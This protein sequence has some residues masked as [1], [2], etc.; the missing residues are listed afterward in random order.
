MKKFFY[1]LT[2]P[3]RAIAKIRPTIIVF[4][5]CI[6]LFFL[7]PF[8]YKQGIQKKIYEK[9]GVKYVKTSNEDDFYYVG[10][11]DYIDL[12]YKEFNNDVTKYKIVFLNATTSFDYFYTLSNDGKTFYK[13]PNPQYDSFRKELLSKG[14]IIKPSTLLYTDNMLK[15]NIMTG[16]MLILLLG[17][18]IFVYII[19]GIARRYTICK[20]VMGYATS[21]SII[22]AI[23]SYVFGQYISKSD[24][25]YD[26]SQDTNKD[27][28]KQITFNDIVGLNEVKKD[29]KSLVDFI[30]N[31][32]KYLEAGAKLPKGIIFYGR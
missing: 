32:E 29:M 8:M 2:T 11:N 1:I 28:K 15:N 5:L 20:S 19:I 3:F 10:N 4:T 30:Q 13:V 25:E 18:V 31:K 24:N 26:S 17:I 6:I 14:V 22:Y 23:L 12:S 9:D 27:K 7:Y 16:K 21:K